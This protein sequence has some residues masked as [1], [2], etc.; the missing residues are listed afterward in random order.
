M[1]DILISSNLKQKMELE[2][3]PSVIISILLSKIGMI[4][5]N[6]SIFYISMNRNHLNI[7]TIMIVV[8]FH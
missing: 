7:E 1:T 2:K 4:H 3:Y 6:V 5:R 8:S